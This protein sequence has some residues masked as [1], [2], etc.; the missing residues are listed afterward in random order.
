MKY[1]TRVNLIANV[2]GLFR[3]K[4]ILKDCFSNIVMVKLKRRLE[5]IKF[6]YVLTDYTL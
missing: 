6:E 3:Y 5:Y 2:D 4:I 1:L